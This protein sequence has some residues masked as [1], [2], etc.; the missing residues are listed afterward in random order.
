MPSEY[1]KDIEIRWSDLDALNHV[2]NAAFLR[3]LEDTRL[4][5]FTSLPGGWDSKDCSPVVVNI[6]I[7]YRRE[8]RYPANISVRMVISQASEK[9]ILLDY[10]ISD[11]DDVK[12]IYSDARVTLVWVDRIAGRS[13][14]LPDNVLNS[15]K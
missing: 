2:N 15:L 10:V 11:R 3:Y 5:W 9:R 14:P 12:T 8:L 7:N 1:C 6:D 13:I 4:D